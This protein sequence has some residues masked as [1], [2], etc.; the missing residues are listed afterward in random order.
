ML[1]L[2]EKKKNKCLAFGKKGLWCHQGILLLFP[3]T[4][5]ECRGR[6]VF[7]GFWMLFV[8]PGAQGKLPVLCIDI[9]PL[10]VQGVLTFVA[11]AFMQ[12][13]LYYVRPRN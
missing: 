12:T 8:L 4:S 10:Y 2:W 1:F 7:G 3:R 6:R 13:V 11:S 9:V 5:P